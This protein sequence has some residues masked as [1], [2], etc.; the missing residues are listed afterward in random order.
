MSR[1][2]STYGLVLDSDDIGYL[3]TKAPSS[4]H[5]EF[6]VYGLEA[7]AGV[8]PEN[9]ISAIQVAAEGLAAMRLGRID[10]ETTANIGVIEGGLKVNMV[11]FASRFEADIRL[12]LGVTR[13]QVMAVVHRVLAGYPQA[14]VA[15][16]NFNPPS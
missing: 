11:P 5:M 3:F 13:E 16:M 6:V 14:I 10:H 7:H 15:E 2:R 12:P 4:D 1:I 8:C 9:G